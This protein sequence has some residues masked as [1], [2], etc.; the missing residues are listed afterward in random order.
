MKPTIRAMAI[1][2]ALALCLARGNPET[3]AKSGG[4]RATLDRA[5][6]AGTKALVFTGSELSSGEV[7]INGR[8]LDTSSAQ[9]LDA[10]VKAIFASDY[11]GG[12]VIAAANGEKADFSVDYTAPG[13]SVPDTYYGV[14]IQIASKRFL[15]MPLYRALVSHLKIDIAR[16]PGGQ[17][18]VKYERSAPADSPWDLGDDQEYQF[19]LTGAD[20][21]NYI[22][23]CRSCGIKAEPEC[24]LFTDDPGMWADLADQIVNGLR[25]DLEYVSVGNEPDI[26]TKRNW[27]YLDAKGQGGAI[28]AYLDRYARYH[29]AIRAVKP[30]VTFVLGELSCNYEPDYTRLLDRMLSRVSARAPGAVSTHWYLLGDYGQPKSDPGFPSL[31]HLSVAGNSGRNVRD[32]ARISA[33]MRKEADAYCP[34]SKIVIG[35]WGTSWSATKQGTVV[36]DSLATALYTAEVLEYGKT[37]GIDSMEYFGLSDPAAFAPWNSAMISVDGERMT[38]R[39]QYYV[40]MM[41]KYAWGDREIPVANGQSE[42]YSVYASKNTNANYLMLINRT[43][44]SI[45]KRISAMTSSGTRAFDALMVP[46]SVTIITLP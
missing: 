43:N 44:G 5:R 14:N 17:E 37:L 36:L 34:G 20:V 32:L 22:A 38:V 28:D 42:A 35:E 24:N 16:F 19:L 41:H 23:L 1:F 27:D 40:R 26:N 8:S 30:S 9:A 15:A 11:P 21:E 10:S 2:S 7:S 31:A 18:R 13:R 3:K 6:A 33:T 29:D 45:E 39:P 46:R 4:S 25:Y 12:T